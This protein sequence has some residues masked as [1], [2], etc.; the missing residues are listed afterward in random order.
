[1]D[2]KTLTAISTTMAL[3]QIQ[4]NVLML[5]LERQMP[6]MRDEYNRQTAEGVQTVGVQTMEAIRQRIKDGIEQAGPDTN[7]KGLG[8]M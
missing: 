8:K 6:N 2:E 3:M 1:M 7:G 5:L 4:I